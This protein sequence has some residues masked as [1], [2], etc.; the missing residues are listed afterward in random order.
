M[1]IC[2]H[3][4]TVCAEQA[5]FAWVPCPLQQT[6]IGLT[7][8]GQTLGGQTLVGQTL[9]VQILVS[10]SEVLASHKYQSSCLMYNAVKYYT[11][12]AVCIDPA[13]ANT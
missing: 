13:S 3:L 5:L 10:S 8:V 6:L 11:Q 4:H 1:C 9:G 7:T 2:L 12:F